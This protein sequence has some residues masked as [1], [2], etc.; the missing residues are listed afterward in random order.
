MLED[1]INRHQ[2]ATSLKKIQENLRLI[3]EVKTAIDILIKNRPT[4]TNNNLAGFITLLQKI[5]LVD[6]ELAV[7]LL[8]QFKFNLLNTSL[9][10]KHDEYNL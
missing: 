2:H 3:K 9:D 5:N 10:P 7:D 8:T 6:R 4:F 1:D